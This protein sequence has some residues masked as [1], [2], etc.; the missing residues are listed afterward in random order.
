[1]FV[2]WVELRVRADSLPAFLPLMIENAAA[3]RRE[4]GCVQFDVMCPEATPGLVL[5]Y[6][7][8]SDADAFAAHLKTPHFREF[9]AAVAEMVLSKTVHTGPR[10]FPDEE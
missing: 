7:L 1:M 10:L 2:V 9:D 8:Y 4:P 3:S 5:L 6:E